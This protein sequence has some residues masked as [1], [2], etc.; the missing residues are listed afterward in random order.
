MNI[1]MTQIY[2]KILAQ[3]GTGEQREQDMLYL[4]VTN[5]NNQRCLDSVFLPGNMLRSMVAQI[6]KEGQ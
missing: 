4:T 1:I 2:S 6:W 5:F 3:S